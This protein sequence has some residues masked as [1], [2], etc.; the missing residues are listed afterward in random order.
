[1][2]VTAVLCTSESLILTK[3]QRRCIKA[4]QMLDLRA[5]AGYKLFDLIYRAH[6]RKGVKTLDV[7]TKIKE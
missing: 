1:M 4:A 5:A 3:R 6:I 2:A 7:S